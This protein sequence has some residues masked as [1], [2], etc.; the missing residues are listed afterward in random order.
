MKYW[1]MKSEPDVFSI[2]DLKKH[3]TTLWEGVRNFQARNFMSQSM[4]LGDLVLFYH[5]NA[6][7]PGIA[8]IAKVSKLAQPDP[9]QFDKKSDYFDK[10][11]TLQKPLWFCVEVA[12]VKKFKTLLPLETLKNTPELQDMLVIKKGQRLSIQPVTEKDYQ[13][14]LKLTQM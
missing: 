6:E 3:K 5:S 14:I 10:R 12:F 7:P 1:L 8:G 4:S 9:T 11:A 13:W 2:D